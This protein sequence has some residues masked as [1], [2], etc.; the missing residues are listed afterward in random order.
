MGWPGVVLPWQIQRIPKHRFKLSTEVRWNVVVSWPE[1]ECLPVLH[2]GFSLLLKFPLM[3]QLTSH[4]KDN[5][6]QSLKYFV[7]SCWNWNGED[8]LGKIALCSKLCLFSAKLGLIKKQNTSQARLLP[9]P[10]TENYSNCLV[11]WRRTCTYWK[12]HG[13]KYSWCKVLIR[14]LCIQV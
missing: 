14:V 9:I 5:T 6:T 8:Y 7:G 3:A 11:L 4:D 13:Y 10:T 2:V 12:W 1:K